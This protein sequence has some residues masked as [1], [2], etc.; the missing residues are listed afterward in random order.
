MPELAG[1]A[2]T[3]P[4]GRYSTNF[5]FTGNATYRDL[6]DKQS[7]SLGKIINPQ[8]FSAAKIAQR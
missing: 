4:Q 5:H 7:D 1:I 6:A 2:G 3:V 8:Q